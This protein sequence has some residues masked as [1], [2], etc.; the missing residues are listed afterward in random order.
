M[1]YHSAYGMKNKKNKLDILLKLHAN[2]SSIIANSD[3]EVIHAN[4]YEGILNDIYIQIVD[5]LQINEKDN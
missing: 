1:V 2:Y 4:A 5:L 3:R